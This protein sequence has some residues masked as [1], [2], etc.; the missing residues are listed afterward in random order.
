MGFHVKKREKEK[1][2][3]RCIRSLKKL[4]AKTTDI[5][6]KKKGKVQGVPQSQAQ[7]EQTYEK[8]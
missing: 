6:A 1:Q 4:F 3:I 2:A 7:I 5:F 8:Y